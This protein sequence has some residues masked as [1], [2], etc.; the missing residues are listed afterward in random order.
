MKL[1]LRGNTLR[2]R[3]TRKEVERLSAGA[4][5]VEQ[6]PFGPTALSY[7]LAVDDVPELCARFEAGRIEVRIPRASAREWLDSDRVGV[8]ASQEVGAGGPLQLLLEKD[9]ACLKPRTGE[10]DSDAYPHPEAG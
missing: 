9:F 10:D 2:L 1:R 6:V 3:I 4:P 8:A 7:A 5:V